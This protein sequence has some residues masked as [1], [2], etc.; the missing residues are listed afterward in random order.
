M[1]TQSPTAMMWVTSSRT[2]SA[3]KTFRNYITIHIKKV[4]AKGKQKFVKKQTKKTK[5]HTH[6]SP[7]P[8]KR[9]VGE[10]ETA[11]GGPVYYERCLDTPILK[12]FKSY[13]GGK[14]DI[15]REFQSLSV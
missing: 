9:T 10:I 6:L 12:E 7:D 14:T 15:E 1:P 5:T 8:V 4:P 11:G 3:V 13:A 2:Y